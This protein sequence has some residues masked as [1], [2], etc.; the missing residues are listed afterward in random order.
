MNFSLFHPPF[1]TLTGCKIL[2]DGMLVPL[3]SPSR[4]GYYMSSFF[5][6]CLVFLG[7]VCK[8]FAHDDLL[9]KLRQQFFRV[10]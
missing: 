2:Q 7:N 4:Q 6:G 10:H 1:F 3:T 5:Q 8:L 9:G